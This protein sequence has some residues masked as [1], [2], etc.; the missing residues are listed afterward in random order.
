VILA[1]FAAFLDLYSTQPLLP[2]LARTFRAS[3]FAVSLTVTAPTIAVALAAPYIGRLADRFGLRRVI[4]GSA[5]ALAAATLLAAT[6]ATLWQLIGWRFLQGIATPGLFASAVAYIHDEWPA[7]RTGRVTAAYVSGTVVG[8]VTGRLLGGV[9]SNDLGWPASFLVLGVLG[10]AV[11]GALWLWLAPARDRASAGRPSGGSWQRHLRQPQLLATYAVGFC[12]LCTQIAMFTYVPFLL[13]APP[14]SLS[15]SALGLL[16]LTYITGAVVTPF[17]G[18]GIDVYGHRAVLIGALA[19]CAAGA[20]LTLVPS[21]PAVAAGLSTFATGVFCAQAASSS[22][23]AHHAERDRALAIGL[24]V[25]CYYVGGTVGG[26]VPAGLWTL[27]RWPACVAFILGIELTMLAIAWRYWTPTR[28]DA[29][30]VEFQI[31]E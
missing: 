2:L 15:T 19:L 6:A 25:T 17:A 16:F 24:Y 22:H 23:V 8:G 30:D 4:V 5:V 9:V 3:N 31:A 27:G 21:L 28:R 20:L 7:S 13:A 14:F 18:T 26:A 11:A 29:D 12:M 10:I 1:G